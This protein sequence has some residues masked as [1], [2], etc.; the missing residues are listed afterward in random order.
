MA[1]GSKL[2][3]NVRKLHE[4]EK[5]IRKVSYELISQ[6]YEISRLREKRVGVFTAE[7]DASLFKLDRYAFLIK[8]QQF[9]LSH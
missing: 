4:D 7:L 9:Y 6:I 3:S 5:D 2:M 8:S 1:F